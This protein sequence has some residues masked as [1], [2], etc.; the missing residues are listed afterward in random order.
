MNI[1][2]YLEKKWIT[3]SEEITKIEEFFK[4]EISRESLE[5]WSLKEEFINYM[6]KRDFGE[7]ILTFW[8]ENY[9]WK[10][11]IKEIDEIEEKEKTQIRF[12]SSFKFIEKMK[13]FYLS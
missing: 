11:E 12:V 8:D 2:K 3:D 5:N 7:K 4:Q 6:L 1:K 9:E 10:F 13:N